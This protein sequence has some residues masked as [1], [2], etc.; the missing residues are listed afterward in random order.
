[1]TP[2]HMGGRKIKQKKKK[3][4]VQLEENQEINSRKM[5]T[6]KTSD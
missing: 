3:K 5:T 6:K 4:P 1:M 2:Q